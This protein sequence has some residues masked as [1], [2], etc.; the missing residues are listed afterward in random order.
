V[1]L[2]FRSSEITD[3]TTRPNAITD[4]KRNDSQNE[5]NDKI[6]DIGMNVLDIARNVI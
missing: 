1:V 6:V 5:M 4:P 2:H 3:Q